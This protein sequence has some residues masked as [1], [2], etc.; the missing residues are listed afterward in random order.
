MKSVRSRASESVWPV[1]VILS[2]IAAVVLYQSAYNA[3][4]LIPPPDAGEYALGA[5]RFVYEGSYTIA[6]QGR[7]LP[8]RY[9][10]WF[11]VIFLAPAYAVLGP[12]PG[13]AVY[14]IT[15]LGIAGVVIAYFLGRRLSGD[16]GGVLAG[17]AVLSVPTYGFL[18]RLVMTDVPC[19]VLLLGI[20]LIYV[21]IRDSAETRNASFLLAGILIALVALVRPVDSA[22]ALPFLLAVRSA[23]RLRKRLVLICC[24]IGPLCVAVIMTLI[25]NASTFGSMTRNGYQFWSPVPY[26]YPWLTFSPSYVA[27]NL[28]TLWV[29][30]LPLQLGALCLALG[31][32]YRFR[33]RHTPVDTVRWRQIRAMIEFL[34]LGTGPIVVFH[35]FYYWREFR[36]YLPALSVSAVLVASIV[37]GWLPNLPRV[38]LLP[39]LVLTLLILSDLRFGMPGPPPYRRLAADRIKD[40]TPNDAIIIAA[41]DP[42]YLE[43][44]V[45]KGSQRRIVPISRSIEYANKLIAYRK[46]Q[47]PTPHPRDALDHRCPGLANGGAK[48]AVPYVAVENLDDLRAELAKGRRVFVETTSMA[49]EDMEVLS[50]SEK[51][52]FSRRADFL[53]ELEPSDHP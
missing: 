43:Y 39:F 48:E 22:A 45:G 23:S 41:I 51:F 35:L 4:D 42:V 31:A 9:P 28:R 53:Y 10:P 33:N 40:T 20:C 5:H 32:N 46:I 37:G 2:A 13:N 44:M 16:N 6:I 30:K 19:T 12:E 52:V 49:P 11:S 29:S 7:R 14:P 17:L 50:K 24:L 26:D 21:R 27:A 8:P 15:V 3:S 34:L 25:Y 38:V 36:F 18:G 1:V 47:D